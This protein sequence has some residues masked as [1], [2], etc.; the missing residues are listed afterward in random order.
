L[1]DDA[2]AQRHLTTTL[3]DGFRFPSLG[4]VAWALYVEAC[5]DGLVEDGIVEPLGDVSGAEGAEED[6]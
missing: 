1:L 2:A 6:D 5:P 4:V 3:R